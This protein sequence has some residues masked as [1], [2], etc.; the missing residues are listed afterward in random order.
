MTR[1]D[2]ASL[3]DQ[4]PDPSRRN[5]AEWETAD[6]LREELARSIKHDEQWD[7]VAV[8]GMCIRKL[9][10]V[11]VKDDPPTW[12]AYTAFGHKLQVWNLI[13]LD[14]PFLIETGSVTRSFYSLVEAQTCGQEHFENVV[15]EQLEEAR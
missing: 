7:S 9:K 14:Y 1:K 12:F 6:Q 3:L 15:L 11:Q 4:L 13:G 2:P 8:T 10:W 5:S